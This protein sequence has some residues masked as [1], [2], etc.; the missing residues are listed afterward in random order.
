MIRPRLRTSAFDVVAGSSL[1][2]LH[3]PL[4]HL[5]VDGVLQGHAA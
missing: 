5:A 1:P 2:D 3:N 4:L